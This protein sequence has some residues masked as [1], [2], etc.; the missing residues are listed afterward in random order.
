[1][2]LFNADGTKLKCVKLDG[3]YRGS[4]AWGASGV[5]AHLFGVVVRVEERLGEMS[6][7]FEVGGNGG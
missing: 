5:G 4:C 3:F 6:P 1:M 2:T 7:S